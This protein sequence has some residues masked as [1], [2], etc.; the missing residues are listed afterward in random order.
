MRKLIK[1]IKEKWLRQTSLTVLLVVI[2]LAIFL[3]VNILIR[4]LDLSPIDFT[5]EKLY[6][7]SDDSKNEVKNIDLNVTLY[8]FGYTEES[9]AVILG[10]QYHDV[11]DKIT[12]QLVNT[13]ERPV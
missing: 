10:K 3:G 11:N 5:K 13:S 7:L 6:S 4:K 2:T 9:T 1:I 8:Y 12:V